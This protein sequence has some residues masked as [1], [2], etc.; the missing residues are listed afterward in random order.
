M[1]SLLQRDSTR[2]FQKLLRMF[3][4]AF[5]SLAAQP[6]DVP[7]AITGYKSEYFE[8]YMC[9]ILQ[10]QNF[11]IKNYRFN[12]CKADAQGIRLLQEKERG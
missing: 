7:Y 11:K 5:A 12:F 6:A 3:L 2:L 9:S 1:A 8:I 10:R 4:N